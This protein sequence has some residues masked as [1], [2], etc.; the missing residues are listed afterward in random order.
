MGKRLR[1]QRRGAGRGR[2]R[3]KKKRYKV[4][5]SYRDY[6]DMEK[7]GMLRGQV[8]K[9]VDDP[10]REALLMKVKYDT[11]EEGYLL[12][13]E[14]ACIGDYVEVGVQA[15]AAMG[16]VL[17]IYM[18][19]DGAYIYNIEKTPGDGGK[20]VKAPGSFGI[21]VS[22]EK[23]VAYVKLPSKK[24]VKIPSEGRAQVGV[25]CGGGKKDKPL[26]KAGKAYYKH[27][28]KAKVWPTVRGV[29]KNVYSHPHGGKQHHE[30]KSTTVARGAPPGSKVGHIAASRTGRKKA[31]G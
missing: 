2:Y 6:D 7:T 18:I 22:K 21:L 14:G 9:F 25:I 30:G 5:L 20:F 16:N 13:P 26:M 4:D 29:A 28:S 23:G 19:P 10:A 1:Q 27:R 8:V 15:K 3:S 24:V 12:A 17:P 11:E 31:K